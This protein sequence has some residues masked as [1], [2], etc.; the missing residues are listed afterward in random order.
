MK[1]SDHRVLVICGSESDLATMHDACRALD[2]FGIGWELH[3][4]S[5]HRAPERTAA[6]ARSARENGFSAIIAGAGLAAHLPGVVA[7]LT[8]LPVIGVPLASGPMRGMDALHAVVQ[9]PRGI[10]VATVA[11]DGA[12]NAGLLAAQII[13]SAD[14]AVAEALSAYKQELAAK[15]EEIDTRLQ[16]EHASGPPGSVL[17]TAQT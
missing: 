11:I 1:R 17:A 16:Q 9:M 8:T 4:S 5:A 12:W 2:Q 3:V 10:P 13:G 15:V 6:F 7:S 14:D